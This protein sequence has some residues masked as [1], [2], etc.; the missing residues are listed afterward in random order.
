MMNSIKI[1]EKIFKLW[2][3]NPIIL[4]QK[5]TINSDI[6]KPKYF[7]QN[8]NI[9]EKNFKGENNTSNYNKSKKIYERLQDFKDKLYTKLKSIKK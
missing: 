3:K 8:R 1:K 7:T 6:F 5:L 4:S 9:S 2:M